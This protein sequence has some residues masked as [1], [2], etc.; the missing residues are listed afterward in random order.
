MTIQ[1]IL[2]FVEVTETQHFTKAAQNLYVSQSSLSHAIQLLEKE[3]EVPLFVRKSG[4]KVALTH[5]AE[6]F[7]PYCK[8]IID[9]MNKAE[10]KIEELKNPHSGIVNLAYSYINGAI[11]V[12]DVFNSFYLDNSYEDIK[13]DFTI[14]HGQIK[15]EEELV[16]GSLDLAIT[17]TGNFEHLETVKITDQ[18]LFAYI[19]VS[20]PLAEKDSVKIEDLANEPIICYYHGWNLAGFVE[21]MFSKYNLKPNYTHSTT[22]WTQQMALVSLGLGIAICPQVPVDTNLISVVPIDDPDRFRDIYLLWAKDRTLSSAAKYVRDYCLDY[23]R[24]KK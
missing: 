13:V 21:G 6:E 23:F 11:L 12:P 15:I 10:S 7:L 20:N 5:Y 24:V 17:S 14:N 8:S 16:Q 2:Y 3:L 19:P 18:E 4:K 1:Q 22:S 9:L